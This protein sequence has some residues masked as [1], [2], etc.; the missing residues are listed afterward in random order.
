M[1]YIYAEQGSLNKKE[2][3]SVAM[4]RQAYR[5]TAPSFRGVGNAQS[6]AIFG[7][8]LAA[9]IEAQ[10]GSCPIL[11]GGEKRFEYFR[12]QRIW[13]ARAIVAKAY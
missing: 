11:S 6:A 12:L 13:N 7:D 2:S 10:T 8:D 9:Q 4:C 3:A 1:L 5:K